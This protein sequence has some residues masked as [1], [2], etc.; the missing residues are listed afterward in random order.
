MTQGPL[1]LGVDVGGTFTKTVLTASGGRI[2]SQEKIS[3]RGFSHKR[4]FADGL[5]AVLDVLCQRA[6]RRR[7]DLR[8]VGIGVPGPV[9]FGRGLVLSLTNIRGWSRFPLASFLKRR[10][11]VPVFVENDANCMALAESRR[12]AGRGASH[13]LCVTLGTGVGGGLIL[14]G[15]I[16]RGPFFLGGEV[17]HI[18]VCDGGPACPCGGSGCLERF[19]GNAALTVRARRI[20]KRAVSLEEISR[21]ALRGDRRCRKFWQETGTLIGR[22]L[23]GVVNTCSPRVIVI[24]GGVAAAGRVLLDAVAAAVRRHAMR[25]IK[26]HIKVRGACLGNDAGMVGA[27][28]LAEEQTTCA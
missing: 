10:L 25:Q 26:G 5:D 3:S 19:V 6:G 1:Y 13:V 7:R 28:L 24:G 11:R 21:R 20:F 12:G 9:D 16:Y 23:A 8:A 17:G 18:P 22:T 2:L 15:A 4:R 14:N 27:A